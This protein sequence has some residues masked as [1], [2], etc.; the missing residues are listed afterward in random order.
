MEAD[1]AP[2]LQLL[3][4]RAASATPPV[5]TS[6]WSGA[7]NDPE[8]VEIMESVLTLAGHANRLQLSNRTP[9]IP[10][11]SLPFSERNANLAAR[12]LLFNVVRGQAAYTANSA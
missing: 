1:G 2:K 12:Q 10:A 4:Q 7:A 3:R 6:E 8:G 9:V 11:R 5:C